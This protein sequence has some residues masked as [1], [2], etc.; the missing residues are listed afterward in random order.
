MKKEGLSENTVVLLVEDEI[1][2][3]MIAVEM[4]QDA[5]ATVLAATTADEAW[6]I[7]ESRSDIDVLFTDVNMPG[8]MDG[9]ALAKRVSTLWP[10]I[11]LIVTSGRQL[12]STMELPAK[13]RFLP[14]P[15]RYHELVSA[16]QTAITPVRRPRW[17]LPDLPLACASFAT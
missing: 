1:L 16:V 5:G 2:L 4:L 8:S 3:Q 11:A 7:L 9:M 6:A 10:D 12:M 14:K 13:G 17:A 15:Y